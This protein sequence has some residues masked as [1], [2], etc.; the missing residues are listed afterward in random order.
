MSDVLEE[1]VD[2]DGDV[3]SEP[4]TGEDAGRGGH[5]VAVV[6]G[7]SR[8]I[9]RHVAH[10]LEDAGW[11]VERGSSTVAT[12]TDRPALTAWVADIVERQGRI[13]LLVNN[14]GVIDAEVD[15]FASDPDEWWHT[16]EV[17]VLGAY[18]MTW[19]VAPHMLAAGGGRVVNLNSGAGRRAS[20]AASG[21]A[22]SKTALAR[23]TGSTHLAGWERGIRAF[24]LM[25]GVVRTDMTEAMEA[26]VGRTEW[27]SREEVT[28]LVLALASGDLD[29][30]SGRFVRAGVDTPE[31]LRAMAT[32]GLAEGERMLDL[33]L[34]DDDP[35]R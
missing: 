23:V 28:A 3:T 2:D 4:D 8:G 6:T 13:D 35:L 19:L 12:V 33:V 34:R 16:Q 7:A 20:A 17:N 27:T 5:L 15:L 30:F 9:G 1:P 14:A 26:H 18:L 22:V 24:D 10:A 25:P 31:S 11:V 21:Y 32:R 29:A